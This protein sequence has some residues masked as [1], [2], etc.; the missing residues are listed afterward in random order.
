MG[1]QE[2]EKSLEKKAFHWELMKLLLQVAWADD[3]VVPQERRV[4]VGLA[5]KLSLEPARIT[6]IDACLEGAALPPPDMQLLRSRRAEVI[7]A[8]EQIVMVD[9]EIADDENSVL[10]QINELL[11]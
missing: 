9:D 1:D 6:E 8:A 5:Q 4:L 7:E 10:A 3:R 2:A 11:G